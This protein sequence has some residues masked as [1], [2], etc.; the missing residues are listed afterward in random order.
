M[1]LYIKKIQGVENFPKPPFIIAVNH[2]SYL[3]DLIIPFIVFKY[4]KTKFHIF[5]NSRFYKSKLIKSYLDYYGLIPVDVSKDVKDVE[6]RKKTNEVAF[7]QAL[8]YLKKKEVFV[9]FPE[10]GRSSDGKLQ[11]AKTGVAKIAVNS[12][13]PVIPIGIKNSF[14]VLPKGAF[15]PRFKQAS[16]KIGKPMYFSTTKNNYATLMKITNKIMKEIENLL[17]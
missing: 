7:Q 14:K 15:F 12:K 9:I 6:K 10:G 16:I 17:R 3:D 11:K 13:L 1:G 2:A 5:V 8:K 4:F